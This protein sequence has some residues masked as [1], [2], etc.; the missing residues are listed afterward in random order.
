MPQV[1]GFDEVGDFGVGD[2]VV[3]AEVDGGDESGA[4][5]HLGGVELEDRE[6]AELVGAAFDGE[7]DGDGCLVAV[8]EFFEQRVEVVDGGE[9]GAYLGA[10]GV[11]EVFGGDVAGHDFLAEDVAVAL[12]LLAFAGA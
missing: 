5:G 6:E 9:G 2:E 11:G 1:V 3:V 4:A 7:L 12:N 8:F 10:V